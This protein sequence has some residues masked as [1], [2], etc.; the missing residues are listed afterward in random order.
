[1]N[2][3]ERRH[4]PLT[5]TTTLCGTRCQCTFVNEIIHLVLGL[6]R[7]LVSP[8][9]PEHNAGFP[10]VVCSSRHMTSLATSFKFAYRFHDVS[11]F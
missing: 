10:S 1:M 8:G 2:V 5:Y 4:S 7:F 6:P 9:R 3:I 11:Y